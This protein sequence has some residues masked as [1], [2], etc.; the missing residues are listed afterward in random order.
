MPGERAH[1]RKPTTTLITAYDPNEDYTQPALDIDEI[2]NYLKHHDLF[3][4]WLVAHPE[5]A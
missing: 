5:A 2:T 4:E 1:N 3:E